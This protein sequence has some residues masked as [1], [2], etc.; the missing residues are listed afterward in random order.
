MLDL[1]E[2]WS[3][4]FAE[5]GFMGNY[6]VGASC[7]LLEHYPRFI[8]DSSQIYGAS[9]GALM[10]AVLAIGSHIEKMFDWDEEWNISFAGCGFRSVYYLGA[11]SCF[12]QNVPR[13]VHGASR[14][15]GAS[16]GCL[17]AAALTV[18]IPIEQFCADVL[19]VAR[20]AR[21]HTLG[22]FHP[23]FSLLRTVRASLL[24][25]LP[26][27]AHLKASGRLCV[28]LTRLTD[29]RNVLVSE[30]NSREELIQVL[31]CSCFFPVYCG[32]TPPS[33]RGVYYMDGALSNNMPLFERRNTI[34]VAPFSG[35]SDVCPRDGSFNFIEVHYGNVSI[36][37]NSGNVHR[38]WTSFLPPSMEDLAE[39]C[40]SGYMDA[41]Q[42]LR[43]RDLL[44]TQS[45]CPGLIVETDS[46]NPACCELVKKRGSEELRL[47]GLNSD[48]E[49]D[50][51]LGLKVEKLPA[52]IKKVLCEAV[53]D[54]RGGDSRGSQLT[55]FLPVKMVVY[56][57][58]LLML[59]FEMAFS[60]S[61]S[62]ISSLLTSTGDLFRNAWS[63]GGEDINSAFPERYA[64]NSDLRSRTGENNKP[65]SSTDY[66]L[67]QSS[68]LGHQRKPGSLPP[69]LPLLGSPQPPLV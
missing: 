33:Y 2:D 46:V 8:L 43:E 65:F 64:F 40:H 41:L 56:L 15:C 68:S 25:K 22:V 52:G 11:L 59:P 16:S 3:I 45:L 51:C 50:L 1:K 23:S 69:P 28:S 35:E 58:S 24:E 61:K 12:L 62:L 17:V 38:I 44:G 36:H 63:S 57:L 67:R 5:C 27:D 47:N 7:C 31:M 21:R 18:G 14:I 39:I 32:F 4:S 48:E 6:Y 29:G 20:E 42:F 53:R 66:K 55:E 54:S 10:A 26:A 13:L 34:T 49:E 9:A 30:F 37:V 19:S 60:L